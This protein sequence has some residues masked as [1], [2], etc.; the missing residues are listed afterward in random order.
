M[1]EARRYVLLLLTVATVLAWPSL[2]DAERVAF[3]AEGRV[4]KVDANLP[5]RSRI[6]V[7]ARFVFEFTY[8]T[9]ANRT[10]VIKGLRV[11]PDEHLAKH[12]RLYGKVNHFSRTGGWDRL[13]LR[14]K[15]PEASSVHDSGTDAPAFNVKI[16]LDSRTE[17]GSVPSLG[18]GD[19][20]PVDVLERVLSGE[21]F[22][23]FLFSASEAEGR[24]DGLISGEITSVTR[25][26]S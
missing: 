25:I 24:S 18:D 19:A 14:V 15:R 5:A 10:I 16:A 26:G 12:G 20:L 2:A 21:K 7:G 4:H 23:H 9:D 8:E 17:V 3:R 11:G 1:F 6:S 22:F 13:R